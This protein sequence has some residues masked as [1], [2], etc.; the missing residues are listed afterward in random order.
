MDL[1]QG[2]PQ[3]RGIEMLEN[4][5]HRDDIEES[6]VKRESLCLDVVV[7]ERDALFAEIVRRHTVQAVA[8]GE[9]GV[10]QEQR[11]GS[12]ADIEDASLSC[13]FRNQRVGLAATLTR[14]ELFEERALAKT[15]I[16]R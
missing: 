5:E 13:S 14:Q 6:A 8:F 4:G 9:I 10:Q 2:C 15:G 16:S 1:P 3:H 7:D 11:I 12:A